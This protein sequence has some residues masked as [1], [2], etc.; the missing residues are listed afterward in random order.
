M[1]PLEQRDAARQREGSG[2]VMMWDEAGGDL[3]QTEEMALDRPPAREAGAQDRPAVTTA[4][5]GQSPAQGQGAELRQSGHRISAQPAVQAALPGT[6][7]RYTVDMD[8]EIYA[9]GSRYSFHWYCL[10]DPVAVRTMGKAPRVEGPDEASWDAQ[11][12][13]PGEHT[14]ACRVQFHPANG[15]AREPEIL[16]YRQTVTSVDAAVDDTFARTEAMGDPEQAVRSAEMYQ[17]LL[18]T[19]EG[20]EGSQQLDPQFKEGLSDYV[21]RSRERLASTEGAE[22]IP[23]RAAHVSVED[24]RT[25]ELRVFLARTGSR[26]AHGRNLA[27][28]TWTLVDMTNPSDR[29]LTGEYTGSGSDA[30]SA[31]QAALRSW[32]SANR[33]PT[34][35]LR[36]EVPGEVTGGADLRQ[37]IQTDGSSFWDSISDFFNAVGLVAGIGALAAAAVTAVLPVPG[38]RVISGLLWTAI[39][40]SSASAAINIGQRAEEGFSNFRE[41]GFDL[42]TVAG[43]LLGAGGLWA[44]GASVV[45]NSRAGLNMTRG[46][47]LGQIATDGA[48]GVMLA[49]EYIE[50]YEEIMRDPD[51]QARTDRMLSLLS[52][53]VVTGGLI[54]FSTWG[55][56]REL[57]EISADYR[58]LLDPEATIDLSRVAAR[59]VADAAQASVSNADL[60]DRIAQQ[61]GENIK[62]NPLRQAYE[63]EVAGLAARADA[64]RASEPNLE[65]VARRMHQLRID[66]SANYK[67]LTPEALRQYIFEVNM[68]RYGN[69]WGPSFEYL[70]QKYNGDYE[71]I[72]S[73]ATRPNPDVNGLLGKFK[74]WLAGQ[75]PDFLQQQARSLGL[76]DEAGQLR[77]AGPDLTPAPNQAQGSGQ[78]ANL[79]PFATLMAPIRRFQVPAGGVAMRSP[80]F[81]SSSPHSEEDP[82][83]TE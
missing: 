43:N 63:A 28:E 83:Q 17:D 33:Y 65:A 73:A 38:S 75:P 54:A 45:V 5:L 62:G 12:G 11:W 57:Q 18:T 36:V 2:R 64:L 24:T 34:G 14:V 69:E 51:P 77:A 59:E 23:I 79:L 10:N 47:I 20:Q 6:R 72:I 82:E 22:R 70:V 40:A 61:L 42:L 81:V 41:D 53:V 56:N 30:A 37:D 44:R 46:I 78:Q 80:S 66:T 68:G 71:Q 31:I 16:E 67:H 35:V 1:A 58:R 49:A 76:L 9:Q 60:A 21:T 4:P 52:N 29:R 8:A 25:T 13:F 50:Q 74:E 55:S 32:D 27:G 39:L 26:E 3:A 48:Q 7:I 15:P 19:A